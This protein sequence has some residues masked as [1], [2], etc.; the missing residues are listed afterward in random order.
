MRLSAGLFNSP[1][2]LVLTSLLSELSKRPQSEQ[3]AAM[4][5]LLRP[6]SDERDKDVARKRDQ[7]SE[8]ARIVIPDVVDMQRRERC[9]ADPQ[10]FLKTYLAADFGQ[11]FGRVHNR[12][13]ESIHDRAKYG[14]KKAMAAP[15]SRGK[16]TII[17]GMNVYLVLAELVRFIVPICATTTLA[18]RIYKDFRN[19]IGT[20]DL[21]YADFPEVCHPVRALDGAP[22]RAAKQHVDGQL[23][24][25]VWTS[26]DYLSLPHV[27]G[28]PYGGVKMAFYGFDAAF[29]GLNIDGDRPDYLNIDD[30]ETRESAKSLSQIEDRIEILEKDIEGLEGQD[31]PMA[32]S[33]ITTCQNRYCMSYRFT[34]RKIK[35][36]W[37]GERYGWVES[38]PDETEMWEEY[39]SRRHAAQESGDR[40]G[41]DAVRFYLENREKMDK[42]V[43]ML[44]DNY[45]EITLEDGTELVHS[46]IQEAFNKI[47]DTSIAA[48]RTEYQ[49]DPEPEEEIQTIG[50][51]PARVQSR[52][53]KY[54]QRQ[55]ASDA[56]IRVIGIDIGKY[57]SH[58]TDT[59]WRE[60]AAGDVVDYGIMET[61][62]LSTIS[63]AN[64]IEVALLAS[65]DVWADEVVA[66]INPALCLID[67]GTFTEA[68]Y[69]FCRRR[70]RPF[71][72]AKGWDAGRFRMPKRSDDKVPFLEA[73]ASRQIEQATWLYN[74][75]TE[76]WKKWLQQRF[77]TEPYDAIGNRNAGS[78]CVF[79]PM[80]DTKRHLSFAHHICAEEEQLV[81]VHGKE[82]KRVWFVK[83]RN[84]HW[85]DSTALACAA[86]GV[87]G[88]RTI[89]HET[90]AVQPKQTKFE[91]NKPPP[92]S[93][94]G[95]PFLVTQR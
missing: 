35:P 44:A 67:S 21:L 87:L 85:L 76:W 58:W 24:K 88:V 68:V 46:A 91:P 94:D 80:G 2:D 93:R 29:R 27:P 49:N 64:A 1:I 43:V 77:M 73:Y 28:S 9:L 75:N 14:G 26:S 34:D 23:T 62:G 37:D 45:K 36:A 74:V 7:R 41:M 15:R 79:D 38:W 90:A 18:S 55:V 4:E 17:K 84:N 63:D 30:P 72:P 11:P 12:L 92:F 6:A 69:E 22:Q 39:V 3:S 8:A 50:L 89:R 19:K 10:L 81:P 82:M 5:L 42:G 51:T 33:L 95:R 71:Y 16:S 52:I 31:S 61:H 86:A 32:I 56:G 13:I 60:G 53:S 65:L 54:R 83:N 25:I 66:S 40:H 78:L 70:G 20:N 59:A 47:A 48:F 57:H